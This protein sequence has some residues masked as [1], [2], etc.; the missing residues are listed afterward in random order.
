[1]IDADHPPLER[2]A[3]MAE[4]ASVLVFDAHLGGQPVELI[5]SSPS[6]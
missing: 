3:D 5:A 2:W 4:A 1:V 6:R